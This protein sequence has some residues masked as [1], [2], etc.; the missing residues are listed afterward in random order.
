MTISVQS[1]YLF[2]VLEKLP[3]HKHDDFLRIIYLVELI[4][5]HKRNL[6]KA[7][8]LEQGSNGW[9]RGTLVAP[10]DWKTS[11]KLKDESEK[12]HYW[13]H[14]VSII[15]FEAFL[16]GVV[17]FSDVAFIN[18]NRDANCCSREGRFVRE[19]SFVY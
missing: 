14:L 16:T 10:N 12:C 5:Y 6:D 2:H 3:Q 15:E 18:L 1:Q 17:R 7:Q 11:L 19:R 4:D 13:T 8:K 9:M